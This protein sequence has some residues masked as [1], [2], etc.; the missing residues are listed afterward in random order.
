MAFIS[1]QADVLQVQNA[2]AGTSKSIKAISKKT[3]SIIAKGTVKAIKGSIKTNLKKHTGELLSCYRYKVKQDA[4]KANV[5]PNGKSGASIFPKAYV[6][7]YGYHG[8]TPRA[9]NK[10]HNFVQSGEAYA[11]NGNYMPEVEKMVNTELAKFW[12][13]K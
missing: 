13:K 5:Y 9:W 6:L 8:E 10:A 3:L 1:V 7:N 11:N 2:L 12:S 4:S